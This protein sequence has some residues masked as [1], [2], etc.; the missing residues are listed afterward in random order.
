MDLPETSIPT[1]HSKLHFMSGKQF[2]LTLRNREILD[3]FWAIFSV[4]QDGAMMEQE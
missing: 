3:S 4:R 2:L 1:T